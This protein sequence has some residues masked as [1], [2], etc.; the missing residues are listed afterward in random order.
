MSD[1]KD[2]IDCYN[3]QNRH[4]RKETWSESNP[5]GRWRKFT[6]EEI[7]ARPKTNLDFKWLKDDAV[8]PDDY[9]LAEVMGELTETGKAYAAALKELQTLAKGIAE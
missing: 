1:L 7:L 8:T 4:K 9:T 3:P 2:F 6:Y 5:E